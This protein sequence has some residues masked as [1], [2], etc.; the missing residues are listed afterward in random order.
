MSQI[1]IFVQGEGI[2]EITV[3]RVPGDGTVRDILEAVK[4]E[5]VRVG[6]EGQTPA[7]LIEDAGEA[8]ALDASLEAVGIRQ[9]SRVHVHRCV[10]VAVTVNF[11][12]RS[13][14]DKFAASTTIARVKRWATG[15]HGFNLSE[16]DEAE[17]ALQLVNSG[18]RPDEDVHIGAL[19]ACPACALTFDLVP[20]QRVEG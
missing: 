2:P 15:K 7:V 5:G 3:V 10:Q 14:A 18:T 4:A 16:I 9:R 6:G 12:G 1:E 19:V 8:L 20:K 11:G 17:H 13:I